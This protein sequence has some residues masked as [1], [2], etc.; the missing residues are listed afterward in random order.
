MEQLRRGCRTL[1]GW[2]YEITGYT[3][4]GPCISE[5]PWEKWTER[6]KE[7]DAI[8]KDP[9]AGSVKLQQAEEEIRIVIAELASE[10]YLKKKGDWKSPHGLNST[11]VRRML[12]ECSVEGGLIDRIFQTFETTD[13]AHHAPV[14]Y[15]AQ[16]ERIRRYHTWVHELAQLVK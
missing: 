13:D 3:K 5:V 4:A 6:L 1:N 9:N 10:L 12:L 11:K 7:V 2:F 15:A 16:R 8:I 14:D